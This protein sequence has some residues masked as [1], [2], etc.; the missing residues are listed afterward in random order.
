MALQGT[1]K[2]LNKPIARALDPG[3]THTP[4]DYSDETGFNAYAAMPMKNRPTLSDGKEIKLPG[5][6]TWVE[7][8]TR[9]QTDPQYTPA[10]A[11]KDSLHEFQRN[12]GA[13]VSHSPYFETARGR[14]IGHV[15]PFK[16]QNLVYPDQSPPT[17]ELSDPAAALDFVSGPV[18]GFVG[19]MTEEQSTA[20]INGMLAQLGRE[21]SPAEV[22]QVSRE[23]LAS[24]QGQ[25][26]LVG[27]RIQLLDMLKDQ[28]DPTQHQS[29][30]DVYSGQGISMQLPDVPE[31][32][33]PAP[34]QP[35][36]PQPPQQP[37]LI[38]RLGF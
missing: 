6:E 12:G 1:E 17:I 20:R 25:Q 5:R 13:A 32:H 7:G 29:L 15:L 4:S 18:E 21:M 3:G 23:F 27:N 11:F 30:L 24:P 9:A 26:M 28:M 19:L 16:L 38:P 31:V 33:I 8:L 14:S 22:A 36:P 2:Y 10:D 37:Q 34:Q 35:Q